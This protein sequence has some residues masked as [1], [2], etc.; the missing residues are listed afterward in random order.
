MKAEQKA[1]P[2][3]IA[4]PIKRCHSPVVSPIAPPI[5]E[6]AE[7]D[8]APH[9]QAF[10]Q[11]SAMVPPKIAPN[12]AKKPTKPGLK[13]VAQIPYPPIARPMVKPATSATTHGPTPMMLLV[14]LIVLRPV[15]ARARSG[16]ESEITTRRNRSC[17]P[18]NYSPSSAS[19]PPC[20]LFSVILIRLF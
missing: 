12:T 13:L 17:P 3:Q 15:L 16:C 14:A 18:S 7:K 2:M 5:S 4:M 10:R 19:Y 11:T 20:S 9:H 1:A 8:N 6:G